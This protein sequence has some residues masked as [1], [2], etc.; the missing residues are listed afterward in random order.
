MVPVN[1]SVF[2][3][4]TEFNAVILPLI[5]LLPVVVTVVVVAGSVQGTL[6]IFE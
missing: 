4:V 2:G 5:V 3:S 1:R 6:T